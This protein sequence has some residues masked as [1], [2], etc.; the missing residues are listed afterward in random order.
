MYV[1]DLHDNKDRYFTTGDNK[2]QKFAFLHFKIQITVSKLSP[3]SV[4]LEKFKSEQLNES[5]LSLHLTEK[6]EK[7][8]PIV[9]YDHKEAFASDKEPLGEIICHEVDIILNINIPYP[10]LLR[11]VSYPESPGAPY[12][13]TSG[14]WCN[15]K[16]WPQ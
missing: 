11:S 10:P 3:V 14:P 16:G 5:E 2:N 8:L 9:L 4:E 15:K 6:Q 13:K 12:Q 7:E 1:I